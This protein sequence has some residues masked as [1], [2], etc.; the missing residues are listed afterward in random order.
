MDVFMIL[1]YFKLSVFSPIYIHDW[2]T[3]GRYVVLQAL[4]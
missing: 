2:N 3:R 1:F 4:S